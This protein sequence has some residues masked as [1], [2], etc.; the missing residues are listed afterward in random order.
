MTELEQATE[1]QNRRNRKGVEV[2][3]FFTKRTKDV[4]LY[5]RD[6]GK[7]IAWMTEITKRGKVVARTY[8]FYTLDS[9]SKGIYGD[10]DFVTKPE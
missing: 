6:L 7:D 8:V 1:F 10:R 5:D 9:N 4:I 3:R 2:K